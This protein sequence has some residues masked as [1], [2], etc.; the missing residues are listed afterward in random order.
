[1]SLSMFVQVSGSE[2]KI[3]HRIEGAAAKGAESIRLAEHYQ[4]HHGHEVLSGQNVS[5]GGF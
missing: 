4:S 3:H 5:G 2:E 1:M